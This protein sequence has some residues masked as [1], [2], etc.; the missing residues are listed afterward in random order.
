[1]SNPQDIAER[2][3]TLKKIGSLKTVMLEVEDA[4]GSHRFVSVPV[5]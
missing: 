1:V 3:A 2:I 4:Q 5:E